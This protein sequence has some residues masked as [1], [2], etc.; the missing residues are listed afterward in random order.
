MLKLLALTGI[1]QIL[2]KAIPVIEESRTLI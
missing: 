2:G 1:A